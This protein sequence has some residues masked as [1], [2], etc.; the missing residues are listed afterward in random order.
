MAKILYAASG[1]GYG[2]AVRLH[3]VGGALL[4]RGHDVQFVSCAKTNDYLLRYFPDRVHELFGL[5]TI[6]RE[7]RVEV[8][9][10]LAHNA[11]RAWRSLIPANRSLR[12][13]LRTFRPDLVITDFEPFSAFW[14]R[15]HGIPFI[16]LDNQHVLTHCTVD[17]PPGH[18][19]DYLNAYWTI[20]LFYAGAKRYLISSFFDAPVRH[21]PAKVLPPIIRPE[22]L[23]RD[24]A[25]GDYLLVYKGANGDNEGFRRAIERFDR[26]PIRAYGF[27]LNERVGHVHYRPVD[28][29]TFLDDLAGCRAVVATAGHSLVC[30]AIHLRKPMLLLP[31]LGQFEQT[32][33][34][35]Q[36]Q[37]LGYGRWC[38]EVTSENLSDW[39]TGVNG[40][41]EA[42]SRAPRS[43][44]DA[45][46]EAVLQEL[47]ARGGR[48]PGR[49]SLLTTN[50]NAQAR[51]MR[52]QPLN[53]HGHSRLRDPLVAASATAL[54]PETGA[55]E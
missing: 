23:Q 17:R 19:V 49:N 40:Y 16:S 44:L 21:H 45:V 10:T 13:L 27:G 53:G 33:N 42:L 20:R 18:A 51:S 11:R 3:G 47:P 37:Q 14:A 1:D 39:L 48:H 6:Y 29:V 28:P 15:F 4:A 34:A 5:F 38:H 55:R 32:L 22:V 54:T 41:R 50:A 7:G 43:D 24:P 12:Q 25:D 36:V 35:A 46:V 26:L 30:E 9:P 52:R 8:W 31:I 2:H